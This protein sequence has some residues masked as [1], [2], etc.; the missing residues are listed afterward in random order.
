M[1]SVILCLWCFVAAGS[2]SP[3]SSKSAKKTTGN[4]V[5]KLGLI[6]I[7]ATIRDPT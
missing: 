6:Q 4:T 7:T 1:L 3:I 5:T 2:A